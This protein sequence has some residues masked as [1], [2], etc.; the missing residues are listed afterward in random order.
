MFSVCLH[1]EGGLPHLHP[2]IL[3]LVPCSFRGVPQWLVPG[4]QDGGTPWCCTPIQRCGTPRPGMRS[5]LFNDQSQL[6]SPPVQVLKV[7]VVKTLSGSKCHVYLFIILFLYLH[8]SFPY[9]YLFVCLFRRGT[10]WVPFI[11]IRERH[12]YL[13]R[14]S[15]H[16]RRSSFSSK[17]AELNRKTF[18]WGGIHLYT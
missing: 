8:V 3:P 12:V 13:C 1:R 18:C 14:V 7:V 15:Q 5:S 11:Q 17:R 10:F 16:L 4:H 6:R 9:F 2:I